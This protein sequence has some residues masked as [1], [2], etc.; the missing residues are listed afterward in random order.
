MKEL[1]GAKID[2]LE[3]LGVLTFPVKVGVSI[4]FLV[5]DMLVELRDNL[6]LVFERIKLNGLRVKPSKI[7]VAPRK[8]ILFG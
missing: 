6:E 8:S 2:A 3:D 7:I 5:G 4:K 1:L